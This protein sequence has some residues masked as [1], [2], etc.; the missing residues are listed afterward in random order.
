MKRLVILLLIANGAVYLYGHFVDASPTAP[1][2]RTAPL[3]PTILTAAERPA[4]TP[5]CQSLGP[6]ANRPLVM[7]VTAWLGDRFGAVSEREDSLPPRRRIACR[8]IPRARI[9]QLDWHSVYARRVPAISRSCPRSR[10]T[11]R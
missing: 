5:Q 3:P 8:W 7:A 6:M 11:R 2:A 9:W 1:I 10:V 4:P